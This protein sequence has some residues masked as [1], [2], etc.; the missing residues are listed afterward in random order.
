MALAELHRANARAAVHTH[1]PQLAVGR[2]ARRRNA[3]LHARVVAEDDK[4]KAARPPS[5]HIQQHLSGLELAVGG[6]VAAEAARRRWQKEQ[7]RSA[8]ERARA[9]RKRTRRP[10]SMDA[11][12]QAGVVG[13]KVQAA[14][15]E[16]ARIWLGRPAD[17]ARRR[18]AG[19]ARARTRV[20]A[21]ARARAHART[22][23]DANARA[24]L[25]RVHAAATVREHS[26]LETNG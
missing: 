12:Q 10:P 19:T 7:Y 4:A 23:T 17:G 14:D 26:I 1:L 13:F 3:A 24:R 16:L 6:K 20:R 22:S 2:L 25:L 21:C 9:R 15:E 5:V 11:P 18:R 8:R